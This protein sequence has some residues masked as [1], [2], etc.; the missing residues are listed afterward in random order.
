LSEGSQRKEN[1][2]GAKTKWQRMTPSEQA[3]HIFADRFWENKEAELQRMCNRV[4]KVE[5][6]L[7][8]IL[9][10]PQLQGELPCSCVLYREKY[11][12]WIFCYITDLKIPGTDLEIPDTSLKILEI[13]IVE[14]E[15]MIKR[16]YRDIELFITGCPED[17]KHREV[18]GAMRK[19]VK[20]LE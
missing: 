16:V 13:V 14:E 12:K 8:L 19:I 2:E 11:L 20:G 9:G 18:I 15:E 3:Y 10:N 4:K 5:K 1:K 17:E 7:S 6:M